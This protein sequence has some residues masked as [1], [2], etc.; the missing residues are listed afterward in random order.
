MSFTLKKVTLEE[1]RI[2]FNL[3]SD[4]AKVLA[5]KKIHQWQYWENPP[6]EKI[7]WVKEG[8]KKE[9]FF[10]IINSK[11]QT[12]GMVRISNDDMLYWGEMNDKS[13]YIHSL[14]IRE[15]FSGLRLGVKVVDKIKKEAILNNVEYLRL[16]CDCTN[17]KLCKYYL[18]QGFELVGQKQLSLG[19]YNLYQQKISS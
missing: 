7:R 4:A 12:L 14:I 5:R 3:L 8:I 19:K 18:N 16:D 6:P 10:F 9:E 13:K 15:E 17:K 1:K 2:V 11:Q